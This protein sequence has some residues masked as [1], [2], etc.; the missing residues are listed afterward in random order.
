MEYVDVFRDACVPEVEVLRLAVGLFAV[1]GI[2]ACEIAQYG[3]VIAVERAFDRQ[4]VVLGVRTVD[5]AHYVAFL[6][7]RQS[8]LRG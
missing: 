2:G 4:R 1:V 8:E 7:Q 6:H 3:N 5:V